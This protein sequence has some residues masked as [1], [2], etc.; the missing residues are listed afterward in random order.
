[1]DLA[2]LAEG[3]RAGGGAVIHHDPDAGARWS[4]ATGADHQDEESEA[5]YGTSAEAVARA[6]EFLSA[7]ARR[8]G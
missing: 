4:A 8:T 5:L 3:E 7:H 6:T 2:G 1:M